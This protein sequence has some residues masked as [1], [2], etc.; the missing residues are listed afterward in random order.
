MKT[1][2]IF[3]LLSLLIPKVVQCQ[4]N[5]VISSLLP[6][7]IGWK[8]GNAIT[9]TIKDAFPKVN[10]IIDIDSLIALPVTDYNNLGYG[11][12]RDTIQTYCLD[13]G[14]NSPA[15]GAGYLFA[16]MKGSRAK[17]IK[18]ILKESASY[19]KID[20]KDIQALIWGIEAGNK[21]SDFPEDF[22]LRISPLL[23]FGDVTILNLDLTP[24][25]NL[26]PPGLNS[27]TQTYQDL[28]RNMQSPQMNYETLE[29]IAI[30]QAVARQ[31]LSSD[32]D[33]NYLMN[34]YYAR[35]FPV[36]YSKTVIEIYKPHS[37]KIEKDKSGR[38]IALIRDDEYRIETD[39]NIGQ[40]ENKVVSHNNQT[41][42]CLK[43]S[44]VSFI[45]PKP[46]EN[47]SIEN[48]G[49]MINIAGNKKTKSSQ[50]FAAVNFTQGVP[51]YSDIISRISQSK[52]KTLTGASI[53]IGIN[54]PRK[55]NKKIKK[56]WGEFNRWL[57]GIRNL[58][59]VNGT[60]VNNVLKYFDRVDLYFCVEYLNKSF[61]NKFDP[62]SFVAVSMEE[63][64]MQRLGLSVR[65]YYQ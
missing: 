21:Y 27:Y 16:S 48:E 50:E 10:T 35:I 63:K 42:S 33:W 2:K 20:Q 6:K 54:V 24:F 43:F 49:W 23:D 62:T 34:G 15:A 57:D 52:T 41:V 28:R 46:E 44:K 17:I 40:D 3:I 60:D 45:S 51:T 19:P 26:I 47:F 11:Y 31:G 59:N 36:S 64:N 65:K 18:S 25:Y 39:Y 38:I 9:T 14:I 13:A 58:Q 4:L 56:E 37:F 61:K 12:Y 32:V 1:L 8:P 55:F 29:R 5:D 7:E 53:D 30:R 22:R